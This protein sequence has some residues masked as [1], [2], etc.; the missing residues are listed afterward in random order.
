MRTIFSLLFVLAVASCSKKASAPAPATPVD[1]ASGTMVASCPAG[2]SPQSDAPAC[3]AVYKGCC[4]ADA[5]AACAASGCGDK[6]LQQESMPVQV[7]CPGE[8]VAPAQ[9]PANPA[10]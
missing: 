4:F 2:G 1:P 10:Q 3:G 5:T 8:E 6:C 7:A 9:A